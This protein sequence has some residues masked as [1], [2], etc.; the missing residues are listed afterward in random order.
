MDLD[1]LPEAIVMDRDSTLAPIAKLILPRM[2]IKAIRIGYKY[3]WRKGSWSA[4]TAA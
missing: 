2:N 1:D 4:S 3:P